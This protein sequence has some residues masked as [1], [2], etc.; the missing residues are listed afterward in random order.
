MTVK[1]NALA[2]FNLMRA[3]GIPDGRAI[4]AL[5]VAFDV[6]LLHVAES[7]GVSVQFV[8]RWLSGKSK[9]EKVSEVVKRILF[10]SGSAVKIDL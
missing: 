3:S 10:G 2:I 8:G 5:L 1:K 7:A 9:S 4:R 6:R